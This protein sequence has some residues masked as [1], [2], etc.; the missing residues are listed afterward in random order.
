[1]NQRLYIGVKRASGARTGGRP[2]RTTVIPDVIAT[3]RH[4]MELLGYVLTACLP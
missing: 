3:R 2:R 1:M 4:A